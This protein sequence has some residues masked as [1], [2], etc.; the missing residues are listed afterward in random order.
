MTATAQESAATGLVPLVV[1]G[2]RV[3]TEPPTPENV[4]R[5]LEERF[6]RAAPA[7]PPDLAPLAGRVLALLAA[8]GLEVTKPA[9]LLVLK[10]AA[11]ERSLPL[12]VGVAEAEALALHLQGHRVPRP[13]SHDL[14]RALVEAGGARLEWVTLT[15]WERER[16]LCYA[17]LTLRRPRGRAVEVDARPS[18]AINLALRAGAPLFVTEAVLAQAG[19]TPRPREP[20]GRARAGGVP[21]RPRGGPL[22]GR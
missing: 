1:E 3:G 22:T 20:G 2:I 7:P 11:G 13:L 9:R 18:D 5:A 14:M 17:T 12:D 19:I 16:Q 21:G 10:E 15:R 6:L 4:R 8:E